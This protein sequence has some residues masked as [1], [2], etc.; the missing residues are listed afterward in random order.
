MLKLIKSISVN[1]AIINVYKA[2]D[3]TIVLGGL[4]W[5]E[6]FEWEKKEG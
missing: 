6:R 4:G 5:I 2:E 1:G 3:G